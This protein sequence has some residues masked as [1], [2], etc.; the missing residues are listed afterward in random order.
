[1]IKPSLVSHCCNNVIRYLT[2]M[3]SLAIG[4]HQHDDAQNIY[5]RLDRR[6]SRI[7]YGIENNSGI[8]VLFSV[9]FSSLYV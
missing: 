9:F 7:I 6:R 3:F 4:A 1:M 5:H 8:F 2:Q